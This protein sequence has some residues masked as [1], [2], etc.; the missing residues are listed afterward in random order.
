VLVFNQR[1]EARCHKRDRYGREVYAVF[2]GTRDIGLGQ[3]R[4]G[5][6]WWYREYANEQTPEDQ[7][8]YEGAED[9]AK[10]TRRGLW[11]D[12]RPVPPWEFRRVRR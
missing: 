6:A 5:M 3:V 4:S 10:M 2:V 7:G 1:V 11:K 9:A 12:A 8:A